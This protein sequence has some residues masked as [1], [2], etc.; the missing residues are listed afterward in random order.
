MPTVYPIVPGPEIVERLRKRRAGALF[1]EQFAAYLGSLSQSRARVSPRGIE[2]GVAVRQARAD[3]RDFILA[4]AGRLGEFGAPPWR[5]AEEI[6]AG[7][8]RT[9][10]GFF[11]APAAGS[12]LLLAEDP[13][14]RRLGFAFLESP[15]DYFTGQKHGHIGILAVAREAEGSR[16]GGALLREAEAWSRARGFARLTLNVFAA[17]A[18]ARDVYEHLGYAPETLRYVKPLD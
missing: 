15:T 4:T 2:V 7:E 16:A 18:H 12:A 6:V 17:N 8:A 5:T 3:D 9:L 1:N 13:G 10:L 14:G 11:E